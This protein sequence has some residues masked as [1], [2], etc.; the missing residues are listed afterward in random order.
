[1]DFF[2]NIYFWLRRVPVSASGS[3]LPHARSFHVGFT[4][5]VVQAQSLLSVGLIVCEILV[6]QA[7]I[8]LPILVLEAFFNHWTTG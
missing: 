7:G 1:M 4:L 6:L 3:S 8:E 5:A 2:K